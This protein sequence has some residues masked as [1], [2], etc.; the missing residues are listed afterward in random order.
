M[1]H[2][3]VFIFLL[4]SSAATAQTYNIESFGVGINRVPTKLQ[5]SAGTIVIESY[6][7]GIF[8]EGTRQ[9]I[10]LK[11]ERQENINHKPATIWQGV[12]SDGD[13]CTLI[14]YFVDDK[15]YLSWVY[16]DIHVLFLITPKN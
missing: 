1:R 11:T 5:A 4:L 3:L 6:T 2:K 8:H 10:E 16:N 15:Q 14:L 7:I 9:G 13:K 12:D